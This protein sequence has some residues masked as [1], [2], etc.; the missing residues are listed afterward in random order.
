MIAEDH[1]RMDA[2]KKDVE[3]YASEVIHLQKTKT[4]TDLDF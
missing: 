3:I 4:G 1:L 2:D